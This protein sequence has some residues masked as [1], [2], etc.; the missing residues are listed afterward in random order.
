MVVEAL[1][2]GDSSEWADEST[3]GYRHRGGASIPHPRLS[4]SRTGVRARLAPPRV[5]SEAAKDPALRPAALAEADQLVARVEQVVE[6]HRPD[7]AANHPG[8]QSARRMVERRRQAVGALREG[9][10]G[11]DDVFAASQMIVDFSNEWMAAQQDF[12]A[13]V[14]RHSQQV[15]GGAAEHSREGA[16]QA[17]EAAGHPEA[18]RA[19]EAAEAAARGEAKPDDFTP[20]PSDE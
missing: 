18:R 16:L 4:V 19:L 7:D 15:L 9:W 17:A 11:S 1:R 2:M 10:E 8:Y 12:M 14:G 5:V 13:T 3:I 20:A 6:A